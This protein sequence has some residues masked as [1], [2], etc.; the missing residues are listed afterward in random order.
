MLVFSLFCMV[1]LGTIGFI[2]MSNRVVNWDGVFTTKIHQFPVSN[3]LQNPSIIPHL[4]SRD[5]QY[6]IFQSL[7]DIHEL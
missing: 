4:C 6:L 5:V 7:F 1:T 2:D 3:F